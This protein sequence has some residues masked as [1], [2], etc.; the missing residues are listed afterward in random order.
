MSCQVLSRAGCHSTCPNVKKVCE[1]FQNELSFTR[2]E[3]FCRSEGFLKS[4]DVLYRFYTSNDIFAA[5]RTLGVHMQA[6]KSKFIS[7]PLV[8]QKLSVID[9]IYIV[10]SY[11]YT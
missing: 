5:H 7:S 6:L 11:I 3:I 8:M 1:G 10:R 2:S 4:I 9:Y